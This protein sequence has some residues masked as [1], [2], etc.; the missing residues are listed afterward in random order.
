MCQAAVLEYYVPPHHLDQ[1]GIYMAYIYIYFDLEIFL[2]DGILKT[3]L[4]IKP[5][6]KQLYLDFNSNHPGHCK[7][8]IP[9]RQ[10]LRV[11]EK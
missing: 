3:D 10:A 11:I 1:W 2:E 6:N 5:T 7:I 4:H 9:Y 8:G